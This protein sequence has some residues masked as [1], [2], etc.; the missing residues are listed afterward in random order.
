VDV[1]EENLYVANAPKIEASHEG[2]TLE[3]EFDKD[4]EENGFMGKDPIQPPILLL[5]MTKKTLLLS[6]H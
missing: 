2:N 3:S 5:L 4:Y 6:L 1:N